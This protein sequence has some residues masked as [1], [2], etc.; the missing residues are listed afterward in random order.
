MNRLGLG[1][2]KPINARA[3]KKNSVTILKNGKVA[4]TDKIKEIIKNCS[5]CVIE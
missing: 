3:K 4:G 1:S 2:V 5:V